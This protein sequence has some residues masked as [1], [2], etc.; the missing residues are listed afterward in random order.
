MS[1]YGSDGGGGD[2]YDEPIEYDEAGDEPLLEDQDE[3]G[4]THTERMEVLPNGQD[5]Q[6][7][8]G[9]S[10]TTGPGPIPKDQRMTTPYMTKYEKARI[11]GTRALQIS[12]NAPVMVDLTGESDP[13]QIAM[14]ELR[15]RKVPLMVR[16]FMPD[17]SWEDWS[18]QELIPPE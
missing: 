13:L 5:D 3:Y 1:D 9:V 7:A 6:D 16:R 12:M 18:V 2:P 8:R 10:G 17:G 4:Q 11:L 15:E 14:K